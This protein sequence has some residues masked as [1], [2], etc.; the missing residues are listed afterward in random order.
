M[1]N[2][3]SKYSNVT[4]FNFI[5][6]VGPGWTP[7]LNHNP[8]TRLNSVQHHDRGGGYGGKRGGMRRKRHHARSKIILKHE[9][10]IHVKADH[11]HSGVFHP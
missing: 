5:F 4:F 1:F 2:Q 8:A 6:D 7:K 11:V 9:S 10:E 3:I